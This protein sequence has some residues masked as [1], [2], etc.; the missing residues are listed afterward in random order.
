MRTRHAIGEGR[1]QFNLMAHN[2]MI[3]SA[4]SIYRYIW[5]GVLKFEKSTI[6]EKSQGEQKKIDFSNGPAPKENNF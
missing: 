5:Q 4:M 3:I 2:E 6:L 1:C